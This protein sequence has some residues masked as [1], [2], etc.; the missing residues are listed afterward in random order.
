MR[1]LAVQTH[2]KGGI[3]NAADYL[4][5]VSPF[6]MIQKNTSHQVTFRDVIMDA[7]HTYDPFS[8]ETENEYL[9]IGKN[10]DIAWMSYNHAPI[11]F[12]YLHIMQDTSPFKFVY[13]YDD[14]LLDLDFSNPVAAVER[15]KDPREG[16]K[17]EGVLQD[18]RYICTTSSYLTKRIKNFKGEYPHGYQIHTIPNFI[19]SNLYIPQTKKRKKRLKIGFYGSV[20][21][22]SDITMKSVVQALGHIR[23]IYDVDLEIIGNFIPHSLDCLGEYVSVEGDPDYFRWIDIWKEKV[24]Q[25]DIAIAPL[26]DTPFNRA[27]SELKYL[28]TAAAGVP[29]IASKVDVYTSKNIIQAKTKDEWVGAL[30]LLIENPKYRSE[31]GMRAQEEVLSSL[32]IQKN[33]HLWETAIQ[34]IQ[35]NSDHQ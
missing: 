33:Y 17:I 29:L 34:K 31:L 9:S 1:I 25:W 23:K 19:D 28:E 18:L 30:S 32:T 16:S 7:K 15:I 8:R 2:S 5:T 26:R 21:H 35:S 10:Y 6:T 22:Q 14:N 3:M 4:R 20:S 11:F 27:R 13:D 12:G 24:T